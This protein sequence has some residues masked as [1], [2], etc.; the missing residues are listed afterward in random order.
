MN[1]YLDV[2]VVGVQ[3]YLGRT[4]EL[5]GRRGASAWLSHAT[6]AEQLDAWVSEAH[7]DAAVNP[8]AGEADGVV[9]IIL[10]ADVDA[11]QVA[12]RVMATLARR[13]P[14]ARMRCRWASGSSYLKVYRDFF[15]TG[16]AQGFDWL[17]ANGDFPPLRSCEKC[18][19]DPAVGRLTLHGETG[20]ACADCFARY[21]DRYRQP[22]LRVDPSGAVPVGAERQLLDCLALPAERTAKTFEDLAAL[23]E[24]PG[25]RNHLATVFI[26]GNAMG[27]LFDAVADSEDSGLKARLSG[28]VSQATRGALETA[29]RGV[30]RDGDPAVAVIPHV[31]G[32]DD[33]LVS[34]VPERA[35]AFTTTF[36]TDFAARVTAVA[37]L[38]A[39]L[40][41]G[42]DGPSASAGMV[43]SH[44]KF[45]F[46]RAVELAETALR[47]AKAQQAGRVAAVSWL[48]VTHD[49][50]QPPLGRRAWRVTDLDGAAVALRALRE[51]DPAGRAVLTQLINR[52]APTISAA[53]LREHERRLDR[54]AVLRP[55]LDDGG[56]Q[57][58]ADAL[59][60]VRW[61]R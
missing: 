38:V 16:A 18:R 27:E 24:L 4:P 2:G 60:L 5:K 17:P 19:A 11:R 54:G 26:D 40:P 31:V 12:G 14:A 42:V 25:N 13:L 30:L 59:D 47:S 3:R 8:D 7:P 32:G 22:G 35:W 34:V 46:R 55:F 41:A 56:P 9:P 53:R 57:R 33:V 23:G 28:A 52:Q 58:L 45:P 39:Y 61:W 50:E 49:G 29:T 51:I 43:F 6:R 20:W 15:K 10:P 1:T 36:L 48:D 37:G 21:E 44:V